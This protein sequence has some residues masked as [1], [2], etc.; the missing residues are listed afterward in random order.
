M[1]FET[2]DL[3]TRSTRLRPRMSDLGVD[4]LTFGI[5][6]PI[7]ARPASVFCPQRL[8]NGSEEQEEEEDPGGD[9]ILA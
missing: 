6:A 1:P 4:H 7:K 3:N 8:D 2:Q 9:L 5:L